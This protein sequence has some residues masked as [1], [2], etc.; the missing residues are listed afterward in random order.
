MHY[1]LNDR[2]VPE[3]MRQRAITVKKN[4]GKVFLVLPVLEFG[5]EAEERMKAALADKTYCANCEGTG[6]LGLEVF[7]GGPY[8]NA[9]DKKH[10]TYFEGSYYVHDI[11][12][13]HCPDCSGSGLF[14]RQNPQPA[15]VNLA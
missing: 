7:T 15:G 13:F 6:K 1:Q 3:G 11:I 8:T 5:D 10:V 2:N 4:G 14:G 12:L 9:T